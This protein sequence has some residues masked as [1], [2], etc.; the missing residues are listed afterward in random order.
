MLHPDLR[1]A[2]AAGDVD[3]LSWPWCASVV[4]LPLTKLNKQGGG[5]GSL[6]TRSIKKVPHIRVFL[7]EPEL[8]STPRIGSF[9]RRLTGRELLT[10]PLV[11]SLVEP[12]FGLAIT[13]GDRE[14]KLGPGVIA[15]LR[16]RAQTSLADARARADQSYPSLPVAGTEEVNPLSG[17]HLGAAVAETLPDLP[18]GTAVVAVLRCVGDQVQSLWRQTN[19]DG[20]VRAGEMPT[21]MQ[22][23]LQEH[24]EAN[25]A[26]NVGAWLTASMNLRIGKSKPTGGSLVSL[27]WDHEP[28]WQPEVPPSAYAQEQARHPRSADW[29]PDWMLSRLD[30]AYQNQAHQNQANHSEGERQ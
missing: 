18:A 16:Q 9:H 11:L 17:H 14:T 21:E 26:P 2:L 6:V 22:R 13:D 30:E 4:H 3:T 5:A 25:A 19:P 28:A 27:N 15:E 12:G 10:D 8:Q 23:V 7:D 29:M 24:R 1:A 20:E